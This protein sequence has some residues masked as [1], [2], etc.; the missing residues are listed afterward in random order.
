MTG[1]SASLPS[2]PHV[3]AEAVLAACRVL[4]AVAAQS[5]AAVEES[6]DLLQVRALVVI[7]SRGPVSL[8]ELATAAGLHL[9]RASRLCERMVRAGLMTREVDPANRRQVTLSLTFAG[10]HVVETVMQRRW[11]AI[12][13]VL[14]RM[15]EAQRRDLVSAL[16]VFAEAADDISEQDLW[17]MGWTS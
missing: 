9:T 13:P 16:T 4:V 17:A 7:A 3:Q 2:G 8:G 11:A 14:A 1:E 10:Q 12:E 6:A 15:T 5:I